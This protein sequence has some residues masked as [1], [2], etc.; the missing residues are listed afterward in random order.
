MK[1]QSNGNNGHS[2]FGIEHIAAKNK[3]FEIDS[4]RDEHEITSSNVGGGDRLLD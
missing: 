3:A 4:V 1:L 2:L